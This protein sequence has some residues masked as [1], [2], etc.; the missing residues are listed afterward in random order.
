MAETALT[1]W[2]GNLVSVAVKGQLLGGYFGVI[3]KVGHDGFIIQPQDSPG[4][5]RGLPPPIFL[6]WHIVRTVML[7]L[8]Q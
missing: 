1:E 2:E 7:E 4:Q 3:Q 6:P 5:T 8:Q